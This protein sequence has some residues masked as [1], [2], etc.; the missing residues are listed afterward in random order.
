M[1]V[2]YVGLQVLVRACDVIVLSVCGVQWMVGME[3]MEEQQ[4]PTRS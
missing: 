4:A 2:C 1:V 3:V